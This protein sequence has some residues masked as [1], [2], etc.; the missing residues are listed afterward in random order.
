MWL[1]P[2]EGLGLPVPVMTL[3]NNTT[4]KNDAISYTETG[5]I[6]LK[7]SEQA[8]PPGPLT[9]QKLLPLVAGGC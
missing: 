3:P 6:E 7:R 5:E 8:G 9:I 4:K 1:A 2:A